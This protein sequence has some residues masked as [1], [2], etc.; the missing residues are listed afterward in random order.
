MDVLGFRLIRLVSI[1]LFYSM[2]VITF[3]HLNT[4]YHEQL[5]IKRQ[6]SLGNLISKYIYVVVL[7]CIVLYLSIQLLNEIKQINTGMK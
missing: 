2:A 6:L 5:L 4:A 1:Q 7:I 3:E